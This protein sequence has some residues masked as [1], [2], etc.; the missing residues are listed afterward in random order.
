MAFCTD[1]LQPGPAASQQVMVSL[2]QLL[3]IHAPV[4]KVANSDR[5][6]THLLTRLAHRSAKTRYM[7]P[8]GSLTSDR[9]TF[10]QISRNARKH[11]IKEQPLS[12]HLQGS[13]FQACL[14]QPCSL[15]LSLQLKQSASRG[16]TG[17]FSFYR[18]V[19]FKSCPNQA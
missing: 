8:D 13:L 3:T 10:E 18:V 17:S 14:N 11:G 9:R 1:R 6:C 4:C 19:L 15:L 16:L 5:F 7:L 12:E 2:P